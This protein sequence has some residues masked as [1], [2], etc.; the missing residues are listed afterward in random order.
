MLS[1]FAKNDCIQHFTIVCFKWIFPWFIA[2]VCNV[3]AS[4]YAKIAF[5]K[6]KWEWHVLLSWIKITL[7]FCVF[8]FIAESIQPIFYYA[9]SHPYF[10]MGKFVGSKFLKHKSFFALPITRGFSN[11]LSILEHKNI[12]KC[13][14][15]SLHPLLY[16]LF[17]DSVLFGNIRMNKPVSAPLY[18]YLYLYPSIINFNLSFHSLTFFTSTL[19]D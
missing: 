9:S 17:T 6:Y 3:L 16:S 10:I 14:L 8:Y 19:F 11:S 5:D 13:S 18:N 15:K 1:I 12:I 7:Q 4:T 2:W